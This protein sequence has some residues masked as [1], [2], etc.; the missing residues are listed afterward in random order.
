MNDQNKSKEQLIEELS[1]L[2][3]QLIALKSGPEDE[4]KILLENSSSAILRYNQ[5]MEVLFANSVAIEAMG[6]SPA[7]Y[8]GKTPAQLDLED[9]YA[10]LWRTHVETVFISKQSSM[11]EGEYINYKRQHFNYRAFLVPEFDKA[12]SVQSVLCTVRNSHQL[13]EALFALHAREKRNNLLLAAV[14]DLII[15]LSNEGVYLD[16]HTAHP[17]FLFTRIKDCLGK[18]LSQVLP[19]EQADKLM[20]GI[21]RGVASDKLQV[22]EYQLSINNTLYFFEGRIIKFNADSVLG[23]VRNISELTTLKQK[24]SR[25]DQLHLVGEMAAGIGHEIRN[26]MTTVRGYLQLFSHKPEFTNYKGTFNTMIEEL[27]GA[28]AIISEYLFLAKN[29]FLK[30]EKQNLNT[31]INELAPLI[32]SNATISNKY[33]KLDLQQIPDLFLD[34]QE[35]RQLI[36]KLITNGLEAM[37]PHKAVT[38]KTFMK[39]NNVVMAVEDMGPGIPPKLMDKLGTPFVTTKEQGP[40]LGLAICYS[41]A[42]R[43]KGTVKVVTGPLGTTFFIS[44]IQ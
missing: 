33:L 30:L 29:K 39:K 12:G 4:S 36:L 22:V 44:F 31:I 37:L 26:P 41:I 43:H 35:I 3:Q 13:K 32:Q 23:I 38:I 21:A 2:R 1:A 6:L 15:H 14:P 40:G 27:D 34:T 11:F 16:Y 17:S 42:A 7:T 18:H 24:L 20:D 25:L 9:V 5:S 28:N 8:I 19:A 10:K